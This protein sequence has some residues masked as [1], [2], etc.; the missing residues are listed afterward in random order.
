MIYRLV[1]VVLYRAIFFFPARTN[2]RIRAEIIIPHVAR[3]DF[4]FIPFL[5]RAALSDFR[6]IRTYTRVYT[7]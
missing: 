6:T 3:N 2:L 1:V 4:V 7:V 5:T